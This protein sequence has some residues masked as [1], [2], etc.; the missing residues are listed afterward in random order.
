MTTFA[1]VVD[2]ADAL[3]QEERE[4]LIR[5]LQARLLEERDAELLAAV[6]ESR[7]AA[8]SGTTKSATVDEIMRQIRE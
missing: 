5:I 7:R 8:R 3:S 4:E 2:Q 6:E 1:D